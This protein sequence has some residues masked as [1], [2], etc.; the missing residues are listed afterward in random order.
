VIRWTLEASE[1]IELIRDY[2]SADSPR[3]ASQQCDLILKAVDQID[4]FPKSGR[5]SNAP[6]LRE[7][8]GPKT[9]YIIFYRLFPD[10]AVLVG[11]L[12]GAMRR[13]RRL[14]R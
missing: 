3:A 10:A 13:P 11:I 6:K 4:L 1:D 8:A 7:L 14:R 12:H 9:P 5:K 2:I